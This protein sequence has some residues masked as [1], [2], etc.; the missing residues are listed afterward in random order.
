MKTE[1]RLI[2]RVC[3]SSDGLIIGVKT[4]GGNLLNPGHVYEVR[5]ILGE[6]ILVDIGPAAIKATKPE[7]DGKPYSLSVCW[8]NGIDMVLD[9][10]GKELFLTE[11]EASLV[12][13]KT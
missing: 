5:E 12:F 11:K 6:L 1:A 4:N 9:C 7:Y 2:V 3:D 13:P 8:G 10:C